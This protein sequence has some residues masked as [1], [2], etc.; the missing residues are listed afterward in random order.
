MKLSGKPAFSKP[1]MIVKKKF[2]M[3]DAGPTD[4]DLKVMAEIERAEK[5]R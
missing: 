5:E 1:G 2:E 4:H 3:Q